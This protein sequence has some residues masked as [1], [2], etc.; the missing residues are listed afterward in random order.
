VLSVSLLLLAD[1]Y[2]RGRASEVILSGR[3]FPGDPEGPAKLRESLARLSGW[4]VR[5]YE[6][7]GQRYFEVLNWKK[8]QKVDKPGK[9]LCPGPE[10]AESPKETHHSRECRETV[11]KV[12]EGLAPDLDLETDQEKEGEREPARAARPPLPTAEPHPDDDDPR[13]R[14]S[15]RPAPAP[16]PGLLLWETWVA[17]ALDGIPTGSPDTKAL[18]AAWAECKARDPKAP[19]VVFE[20]AARAYADHQRVKGK[21]LVIRFFLEELGTWIPAKGSSVLD[22]PPRRTPLDTRKLGA[23]AMAEILAAEGRADG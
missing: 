17:V 9:P 19:V 6:V 23:A 5:L 8:H 4:Y 10:E 11:A 21:R 1:D 7:R 22:A 2:G 12:P 16:E 15:A 14:T 3:V 13:D 20:R 18:N